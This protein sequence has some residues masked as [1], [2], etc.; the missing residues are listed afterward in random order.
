MLR[1]SDQTKRDRRRALRAQRRDMVAQRD[2]LRDDAALAEVGIDLVAALGLD[3]G[4]TVTLYES[5]AGE[6]PTSALAAAL[7]A[8]GIRVLIPITEPDLDL[9]WRELGDPGERPLG[10]GAV[11]EADLVLAPGL[12]VDRSGTRM[13][14]GGGCYDKALPRR[15][16][17]IPVVVLLHPGE[18][19]DEGEPP[20]PREL[21]DAP[22]DGVL[23]ADGVTWLAG[24]PA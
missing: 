9:N 4:D 21:H 1:V 24:G 15:R 6:P 19:L 13:G 10:H 17:G 11:S 5:W 16:P 22:V 23:T 8:R 18:L 20:L 14:Q 2:H 12:A 3:D 7:V